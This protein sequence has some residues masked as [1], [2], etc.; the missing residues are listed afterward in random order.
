MDA[1][2]KGVGDG[3]I[4]VISSDHSPEDV[5]AKHREFDYAAFGIIGLETCFAAANTALNK[6][7]PLEKI[8]ACFVDAP[9]TVLNLALPEI[10]EGAA[11]NLT[12][13]NP[14]TE[15]TFTADHIKSKS[16]NTP[17][18]GAKFKGK[19]IAVINKDKIADCE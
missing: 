13:F 4:D 12:V 16:R 10:K 5:E 2:I 6:K 14:Q 7:V 9:R 17:F 1:L 19:A 11:A 3:T 8:I 15:W 18:I